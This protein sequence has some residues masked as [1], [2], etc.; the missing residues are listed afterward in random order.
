MKN[1]T[2]LLAAVLSTL[3]LIGNLSAQAKTP[4]GAIQLP[5]VNSQGE[6]TS[7]AG[8]VFDESG[9]RP[10]F[11]LDLGSEAFGV[12]IAENSEPSPAPLVNLMNHPSIKKELELTDEQK[13]AVSKI[14]N[15]GRAALKQAAKE[16]PLGQSSEEGARQIS[17]K[18]KEISASQDEMLISILLPH[19]YQRLQ[20][21][22]FQALEKEYGLI[23]VL[24]TSRGKKEFDISD[25]QMS[26]LKEQEAKI[27]E[28]L[29]KDIEILKAKARRDL[30]SKLKPSQRAKYEKMH[31]DAFSS[32]QSDW[33]SLKQ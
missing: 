7:I 30:L 17:E 13:A 29:A 31:G 4:S 6:T 33:E 10:T 1:L 12:R 21:I 19:Q 9:A 20:Q 15:E 22:S 32:R 18:L 11:K 14:R 28:K 27:K 3:L 26:D 8:F 23:A 2:I 24:K 5:V 16:I 25:Q